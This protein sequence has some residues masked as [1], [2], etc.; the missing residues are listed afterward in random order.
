MEQLK[1]PS[2]IDESAIQAAINRESV[3]NFKAVVIWKVDL[4]DF[5]FQGEKR[6]IGPLV[7]TS[8]CSS[9]KVAEDVCRSFRRSRLVVRAYVE[10]VS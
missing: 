3:G 2:L 5:D 8:I 6:K 1:L 7:T 9:E 10:R 4:Y